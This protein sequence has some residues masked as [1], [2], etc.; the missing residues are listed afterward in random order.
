MGSISEDSTYSVMRMVFSFCGTND[1]SSSSETRMT[2]PS[3][4]TPLTAADLLTVSPQPSHFMSEYLREF[5]QVALWYM[6]R[7]NFSSSTAVQVL[8]ANFARTPPEPF[9]S[10]MTP[11]HVALPPATL[12][13]GTSTL[14]F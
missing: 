14:T 13:I 7:S 10:S 5:R 9:G 4:L 2:S 12:R 1:A 8:I 6:W 3:D 11:V